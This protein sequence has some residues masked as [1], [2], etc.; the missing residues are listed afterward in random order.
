MRNPKYMVHPGVY[1]KEGTDPRNSVSWI[2][3]AKR[4]RADAA[5]FVRALTLIFQKRGYKWEAIALEEMND[6]ESREFLLSARIP[7]G[8]PAFANQVREQI[9]RRRK[10]AND[11]VRGKKKVP[12]EE[13][14]AA[15]ARACERGKKPPRPR[16]AEHRSVKEAEVRDVVEGFE[17]AVGLPNAVAERWKKE[18]CGLLNKVLRPA[19]FRNRLKTG[20][21]WCGRATPRRAR[22][23]EIAYRA[24]IHNLRV[25]EGFRER[26]LSEAET[27]DFRKWWEDPDQ[28]P[29]VQAI[30]KRLKKMNP[31]QEKMARQI[32]DLLKNKSPEGRASLCK[33]HLEIAAAGKTMRDAGVEWQSIAARKAPNP[34]RERRD[35][36]VMRRLEQILFLTGKSGTGAWRHGPV[37]VV[38]LEVPEPETERAFKGEMKERKE[39]SLK[40]R[41]IEE[42]GGCVYRVV[43]ECQGELEKEHIYPRSRGGP[44]VRMNLVATCTRHN[45][46]KDNRTPMEWLKG[47]A[48][49]VFERHVHS[50]KLPERKKRLLLN[51]TGEYPEGDP[52]PFARVGA[53]PRQ[54]VVALGNLFKRRGVAPPLL[55]YKL[56]EPLVQRI[57]G[58][59][60]HFFR[61]SWCKKEDGTE[62]FPYPKDRST[63]FNHAEDAAI[64]AGVPPHTWREQ[65]KRFTAE[66]PSFKGEIKPRP[67]LALPQ[68]APDWAG[69]LQE[70]KKP[71]VRILGRYP[72]TWKS[73]F[74]DQTFWRDPEDLKVSKL[75]RSKLVR[76]LSAKDIAKIAFPSARA[77]VEPIVKDA[78]L[79]ERGSLVEAIAR[80]IAG[81]EA[82][83]SVV[84]QAVPQAAEQMEAQYPQVRRVQVTSQKGGRLAYISP[85]D[86]PSR[87]VQIKPPSEG[88]VVWRRPQVGKQRPKVYISLLRPAPL[89]R[90][91]FSRVD[92]PIPP[93]ATVLGQFR[94]HQII[95]LESELAP[96]GGFY[97]VVKLQENGITV[98]PEEAVPAEILRRTDE[99][100]RGVVVEEDG[101]ETTHIHLGKQALAEYFATR[102]KNG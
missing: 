86:G 9:E 32:H 26:K 72:V 22:V 38:T 8:D 39:S 94:R 68:L 69:F 78:G 2:D 21:A 20:C 49:S 54:F 80:K 17:E 50:L 6:I 87:K 64:L 56:G 58:T 14:E 102:K 67:D 44:G 27:E 16:V 75:R 10:D 85:K 25:R 60:T 83:R 42:S 36:R 29:G 23:R 76:D 52:T 4:G 41:L 88:A 1:D 3:L 100:I 7:T 31:E 48:W 37:S 45:K 96:P 66:R 47:A 46:E 92:P 77:R 62:N 57:R 97:R 61:K 90:F 51:A 63:L 55:A 81:K 70:R 79:E 19:R 101:T 24:A 84:L 91:G 95:F 73:S 34:C 43:G 13:L 53:R 99:E 18:L 82:K 28:A 59:E 40:E 12:P 89:L 71:L 93:G 65:I 33:Q 74:A 15:F 35:E 98:Q 5:G 11:P 30:Q